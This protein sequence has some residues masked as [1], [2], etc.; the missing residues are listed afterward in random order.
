[1]R[2]AQCLLGALA[3]CLLTAVVVIAGTTGSISGY[4]FDQNGQLM[5]GVTVRVVG[6]Q[7]PAGRTV[8]TGDDGSYR[9]LLLLPGTYSVELIKDG[10]SSVQRTV[11]VEVDKDT[12][13]DLLV[14]GIKEELTVSGVLPVVDTKS[15]EVNFNYTAEAIK[16]LPLARSYAGLFQLIPGVADNRSSIGPS[17]GG[18]R[19]DNTY[20]MDGVNI[21]NPSFGNLSTEVNELDIQEFN[22]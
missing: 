1:M 12:Q 15:T 18:S 7:L 13:T 14:G 10:T 16:E 4:V 11:R 8:T 19:Q 17:A 6:A 2:V 9:F 20:L 5:P 21:T 22:I 3:L